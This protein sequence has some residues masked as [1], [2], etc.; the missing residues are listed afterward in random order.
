MFTIGWGS[1][2]GSYQ[3]HQIADNY[4]GLLDGIVVGRSFPD[5]ASA[6]NVTLFDA[7]LLEHYFTEAA[8]G[9]FSR[10]E[11]RQVAG[12]LRWQSIRN[13]SDGANRLDPAAEFPTVLPAELRYHPDTNPDGARGTST[14]TPPTSTAATPTPGSPG[15]RW[16]TPAFS[17][18][19]PR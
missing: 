5:V 2:G 8:P 17:T 18:G 7:R 3:S 9:A 6:T 12:F 14:T 4:P 10:E 19:S 11:Q 16:T 15:G 1:S 13:L